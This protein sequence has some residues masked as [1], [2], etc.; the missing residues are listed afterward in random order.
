M[1]EFWIIASVTV[2]F[3]ALFI[4]FFIGVVTGDLS[5][6]F[7]LLARPF[8]PKV[9]PRIAYKRASI[10]EIGFSGVGVPTGYGV[11]SRTISRGFHAYEKLEDALTH[12]QQGDVFLEVLLSGTIQEHNKGYIASRQRVLQIISHNCVYCRSSGT[13][14]AKDSGGLTFFCGFHAVAAKPGLIGGLTRAA[15]LDPIPKQRGIKPLSE[16]AASYSWLKDTDVVVTSQSS[17]NGFVPTLL[18]EETS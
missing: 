11:A 5:R 6:A 4:I 1:F 15:T 7:T 8:F 10:S 9:K 13:H 18:P 16:F 17:T 3:V 2:I 12:P 14:F